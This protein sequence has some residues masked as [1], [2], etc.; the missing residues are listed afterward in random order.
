MNMKQGVVAYGSNFLSA[1]SDSQQQTNRQTERQTDRQTDRQTNTDEAKLENKLVR[2]GSC[3]DSKLFTN[4]FR[5]IM[6]RYFCFL[7]ARDNC[8]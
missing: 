2:E 8:G 3:F 6:I 4:A 7:V 1:N 5:R